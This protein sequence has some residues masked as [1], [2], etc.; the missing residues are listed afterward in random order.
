MLITSLVDKAAEALTLLFLQLMGPG[1]SLLQRLKSP[2]PVRKAT[3]QKI[4][5]SKWWHGPMGNR[6]LYTAGG[7][8]ISPA[9]MEVSR[10]LQ[11]QVISLPSKHQ[12]TPNQ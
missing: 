4:S 1:P 8:V 6:V 9:A 11:D 7:N 12:R 10:E 3:I 5:S 2:I